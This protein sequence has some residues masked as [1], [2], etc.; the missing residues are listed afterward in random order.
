MEGTLVHLLILVVILGVIWYIVSVLPIQPPFKNV[1][2]VILG[3]IVVI[4]L[5]SL[6]FG[7]SPPFIR[8]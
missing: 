2:L 8:R 3:A 7:Y 4:Y 1:V 5:L 6:L